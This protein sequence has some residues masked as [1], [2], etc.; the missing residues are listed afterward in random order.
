MLKKNTQVTNTGAG[1]GG[2]LLKNEYQ[3]NLHMQTTYAIWALCSIRI[4]KYT[5]FWICGGITVRLISGSGICCL[6][7]IGRIFSSVG[8]SIAINHFVLFILGCATAHLK[9]DKRVR[10]ACY[11][12][13]MLALRRAQNIRTTNEYFKRGSQKMHNYLLVCV[14]QADNTNLFPNQGNI[15]L[16]TLK[17]LKGLRVAIEH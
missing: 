4:E 12:L 16:N 8:D 11:S 6:R 15:T 9:K 17:W 2:A 13:K 1:C 14:S 3:R 10:F 5:P 7:T